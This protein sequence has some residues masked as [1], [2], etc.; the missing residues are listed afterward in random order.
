MGIQFANGTWFDLIGPFYADGDHNDAS[1]WNYIVAEDIGNVH[2]IFDEE[3]DE[4]LG[5]RGFR[6]VDDE[7][8]TVRIP[9][10][11]NKNQVQLSTENANAT[12]KITKLRNCIERGFARL[13]QWKIINAT[14]DTNLIS[15]LGSLLRI[16]GAI[17]NKYFEPLKQFDEIIDLIPKLTL[18]TIRNYGLG[19]YALKLAIPY[20]Q[21]ASSLSIKTHK[22][23]QYSSVIK[24]EDLNSYCSC[25]SGARTVGTCAHVIAALYWF[26]ANLNGITIPTYNV[27]SIALEQNITNLQSFNRRRREQ[28]LNNDEIMISDVTDN[29]DENYLCDTEHF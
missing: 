22:S 17:D 4:F 29:E 23:K 3:T 7:R 26:Y 12:R 25:K 11:L 8:F 2:D 27:K 28:K 10:S 20:L 6:D 14:I 21:H 15:K 16:L 24:I 13:K 19:E 18:N 5:D 9:F 1:I